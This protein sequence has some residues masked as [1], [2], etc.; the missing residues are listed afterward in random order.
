MLTRLLFSHMPGLRVERLWRKGDVVH[1]DAITTRRAAHCPLCGRRSKRVHSHYSR[2]IADLPCCGTPVVIHL[3]TRRFVCRVRWCKRKIF[4]FTERIPALVAPSARRTARLRTHLERTGFALGGAP[5]ARHATAEGIVVSRRTLLRLVRAA[6]LPERGAVR[7]LGVDDWAQRKGQRYGTIL[8]DL[9]M[10]QVVDLLPDRTAA[11][12]ATWLRD[13]PEPAIIGRDRGGEYADGARQGAPHALQVADRF[14]LVMNVTD[15]L[16]RFLMRKH[17]ALRQAAHSAST[18]EEPPPSPPPDGGGEERAAVPRLNR[19]QREKQ[20]CRA[21]RSARYEEVCTLRAAGHTIKAIAQR[22][23]ISPRTV[24]RFLH[25]E[26]FP[27][28]APRRGGPTLLTPFEPF[29]H[30]RWD[31]GCHNA[32]HLWRELQQRGFTG[33]YGIVALHLRQWR[34]QPC[35]PRPRSTRRITVYSPRQTVWLLLRPS[36]QLTTEERAYLLHLHRCCPEMMVAQALVEEFTA[37]LKDHDVAGWYAWLHRAEECAIPEL[38]AIAR[39]MW[40][41]RSAVEAAVATQ[42]SNGQTEGQVNRLK[43]LKRTMYGRAKFD[44]LRQRM[45]YAG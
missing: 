9:E 5:G 6:P 13:R 40:R 45:L 39:G 17:A 20:E 22:L 14:H 26:T 11:T 42:W 15:A 38:S 34:A 3:H 24:L 16:E 4:I 2:T 25:A 29:L 36:D 23:T 32:T 43:V 21:R 37:V 27:E 44:L 28:H 33:R 31:A 1:V 12:F 10:H 18:T 7:A 8:V 35:A 41:D 19:R 30:E